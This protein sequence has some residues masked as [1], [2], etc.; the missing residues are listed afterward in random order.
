MFQV[1]L[2]TGLMHA[3]LHIFIW[4]QIAKI[5]S[6]LSFFSRNACF[7]YTSWFFQRFYQYLVNRK[8][9]NSSAFVILSLFYGLVL[10]YGFG[11][12]FYNVWKYSNWLDISLFKVYLRILLDAIW[13][14]DFVNI[15]GRNDVRNSITISR[16]NENKII[17]VFKRKSKN[18]F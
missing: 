2:L 1:F 3:W 14:H 6:V 7:I 12:V 4:N 9:V 15:H 17:L 8:L 13:S 16:W 18:Y 10:F 5:K 11:V